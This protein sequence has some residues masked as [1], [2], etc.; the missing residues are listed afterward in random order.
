GAVVFGLASIV[1]LYGT[2]RNAP[3]ISYAAAAAG[4][5]V[6]LIG[7]VYGIGPFLAAT[8]STAPLVAKVP[9]LQSVRP[10]VEVDVNLPSLTYYA[11][12][13]PERVS[14][15]QLAE[16]LAKGDDPLVVINDVDW[17]SLPP[18]VRDGLREIGRSGKLKV[19]ERA[20]ISRKPDESP[21][22]SP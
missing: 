13:A 4:S 21:V 18:E 19:M 1:A 11:D 5:I 22:P 20:E 8:R 6:F 16:R 15:A 3:R 17:P 7:V 9:A 10:L 12:R 2:M 14:G